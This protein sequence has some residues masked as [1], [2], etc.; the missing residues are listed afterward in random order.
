MTLEMVAKPPKI[1]GFQRISHS[2]QN[3]FDRGVVFASF[4]LASGIG[5]GFVE[6]L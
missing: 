1:Q 5:A 4:P 6:P 3:T 2:Y